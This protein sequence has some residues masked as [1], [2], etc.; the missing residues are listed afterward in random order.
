[1]PIQLK[2]YTPH[3]ITLFHESMDK[4]IDI[5]SSGEIR[6]LEGPQDSIDKWEGI[7][8]YS[9]PEY[10]KLEGVP[11]DLM[12]ENGEEIGI[13]VSMPVGRYLMGN[14]LPN[15]IHVY[16][17]D[18]GPKNAVRNEKGQPIGTKALVKYK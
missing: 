18:M 7:P 10:T 5:P 11:N 13:I 6:L 14:I 2:N 8:V 3:K 12:D 9:P 15:R 16:G 1:M 4:T 17:P